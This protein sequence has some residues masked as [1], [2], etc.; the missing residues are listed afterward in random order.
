MDQKG[1][2]SSSQ[3]KKE[4]SKESTAMYGSFLDRADR[5]HITQTKPHRDFDVK[6][7]QQCNALDYARSSD[8]SAD[9]LVGGDQALPTF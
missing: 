1:L 3:K 5:S 8:L 9:Y 2:C 7:R 6:E 4:I